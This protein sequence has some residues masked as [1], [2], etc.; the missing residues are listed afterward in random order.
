M[1]QGWFGLPC[2]GVGLDRLDVG[3]GEI[4]HYTEREGLANNGAY[5]VLDDDQGRL[6]ISTNRGISRF[7]PDTETFRNYGT[8]IGLQGLEYNSGSYHR[9]PFGEFFFGGQHGFNS[10][11]PNELSENSTPPEVTLV[12]LKLFNESVAKD[13]RSRTERQPRQD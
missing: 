10:F 9:G 2:T 8:E 13:R 6:W 11:F 4:K 12:D 3:S 7:D 5:A 1:S